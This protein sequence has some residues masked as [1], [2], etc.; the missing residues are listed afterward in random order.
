MNFVI[1][2]Y[3][4]SFCQIFLKKKKAKLVE[5]Q[6]TLQRHHVYS[7]F[8]LRGNDRFHVVSTWNIR[9]VFVAQ[10]HQATSITA[11]YLS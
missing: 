5:E 6:S 3:I 9:G 4:I 1:F 10:L 11:D 8:K 7:S 2:T